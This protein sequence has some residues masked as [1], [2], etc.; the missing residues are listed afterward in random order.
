MACV[1]ASPSWL[2]KD[3][4]SVALLS[5]KLDVLSEFALASALLIAEVTEFRPPEPPGTGTPF[6]MP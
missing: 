5:E 3:A 6:A 1:L 4:T 2:L